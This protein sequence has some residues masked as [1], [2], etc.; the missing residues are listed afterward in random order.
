MVHPAYGICLLEA[1]KAQ[2]KG[3]AF[4]PSQCTRA[5]RFFLEAVGRH[6]GQAFVLVL[7]PSMWAMH[8]VRD[9]VVPLTRMDF[10]SYGEP[11]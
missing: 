8:E 7:G 1:K 2:E 5:Q 11:Y 6:G 4:V 10:D 3:A 9:Q